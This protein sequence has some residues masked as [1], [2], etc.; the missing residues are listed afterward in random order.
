MKLIFHLKKILMSFVENFLYVSA[1][2]IDL[3]L[4]FQNLFDH[5]RSSNTAY[6]QVPVV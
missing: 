5:P 3:C 2:L 6:N 4:N 1:A